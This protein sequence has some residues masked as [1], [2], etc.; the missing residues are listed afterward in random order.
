M[1]VR[2]N[3]S[4]PKVIHEHE[5]DLRR[6]RVI[7]QANEIVV[8]TREYD[9]L[10]QECWV[11]CRGASREDA[12]ESALLAAPLSPIP[13][14]PPNGAVVPWRGEWV[15][16]LVGRS[17]AYLASATTG[18]LSGGPGSA[19]VELVI[20]E[21]SGGP[22]AMS[23]TWARCVLGTS[24]VGKLANTMQK[25]RSEVFEHHREGC[26]K[27]LGTP[28]AH[29]K[30]VVFRQ[31]GAPALDPAEGDGVLEPEARTT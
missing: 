25:W 8:E 31:T 21:R 10:G 27:A 13:P 28:P 6:V 19:T 12:L 18:D 20:E 22:A 16:S 1:T 3:Q 17:H 30:G 29:A 26:A 9:T 7:R 14:T 23:T 11:R 5:D 15:Q 4:E 24:D 2:T